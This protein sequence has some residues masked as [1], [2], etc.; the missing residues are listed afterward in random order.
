MKAPPAYI[1]NDIVDLTA[2]GVK[3][4]FNDRRFVER[5]FSAEEQKEI[6][7]A[8]DPTLTLWSLW[9]AKEAAYKVAKKLR[10]ATVFAH[11]K[12]RVNQ[13]RQ[14]VTYEDLRFPV[15]WEVRPAYIHC[16]ATTEAANLSAAKIGVF[17]KPMPA[18]SHGRKTESIEARRAATELLFRER[19]IAGAEVIREQEGEELSPPRFFVAGRR[20]W[21]VDL[22][23]SHDEHWVAAALI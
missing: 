18:G 21:D 2:Q 13:A 15:R 7:S 19:G 17:V 23:L 5:V 22:S 14:E 12:F 11:R 1:G 6:Q 16:I 9:A 4:K 10:P 8:S 3:G 20:L